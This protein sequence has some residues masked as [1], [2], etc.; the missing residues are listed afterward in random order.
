MFEQPGDMGGIHR[1]NQ[2]F[3]LFAPGLGDDVAMKDL[4]TYM[5]EDMLNDGS[6]YM[7]TGNETNTP[8][9]MVDFLKDDMKIPDM[10]ITDM[11][12]PGASVD[13]NV[14]PDLVKSESDV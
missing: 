3:G 6:Q 14:M 5:G 12:I 7:G 10:K 13:F 9:A 2:G 11:K 8:G 4:Q 1:G